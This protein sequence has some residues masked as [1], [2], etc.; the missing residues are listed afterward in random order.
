MLVFVATAAMSFSVTAVAAEENALLQNTKVRFNDGT[1]QTVQCYN[2]GGFNFIRARDVSNHL[3]IGIRPADK[4]IILDTAAQAFGGKTEQLTK[5]KA[6]VHVEEGYIDFDGTQSE[7]E[8]FLLDGRY[9]FKLADFQKASE[10][11]LQKNEY[12]QSHIEVIWNN[13]SRIIDVRLT[14]GNST[15]SQIQEQSKDQLSAEQKDTEAYKKEVIRLVNEERAKVN[16]APLETDDTMQE[17]ADI[18]VKE[19]NTLFSHDRPNGTSCFTVLQE[20]GISARAMGEN[21]AMGQRNPEEVVNSWMNS[22]GHRE[23]I[24]NPKFTLIGVGYDET[25]NSWVQLF[26]A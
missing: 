2:V 11:H 4:G 12:A 7:A 16:A 18:R 14:E 6:A 1:V 20:A 25:I 23:N 24:L 15:E 22:P 21:I 9:Y 19:L 5:Q 17:S 26:V 13:Q 8:C 10:A 3:H